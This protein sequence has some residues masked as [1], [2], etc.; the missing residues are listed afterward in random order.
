MYEKLQGY[1]LFA[2]AHKDLI[3]WVKYPEHSSCVKIIVRTISEKCLTWLF[4]RAL[5]FSLKEMPFV[6][7]RCE[8]FVVVPG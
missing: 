6:E 3:S 7:Y 5:M 2:L 1:D 4:L 8:A